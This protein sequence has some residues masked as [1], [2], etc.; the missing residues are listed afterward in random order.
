MVALLQHYLGSEAIH[1]TAVNVYNSQMLYLI[2]KYYII[3]FKN[4]VRVLF[5]M[6]LF[7]LELCRYFLNLDGYLLT[8]Y[9]LQGDY[10]CLKIS[11]MDVHRITWSRNSHPSNSISY[12]IQGLG[13]LIAFL[14][15][16]QIAWSAC[17]FIIL[18]NFGMLLPV[19]E[20]LSVFLV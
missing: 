9:V 10:V 19:I 6:F 5:L 12:M 4:N 3:K 7:K 14:F 15:H 13:Y 16:E 8:I 1:Q 18:L 2:L 17:S 11:W 20:T